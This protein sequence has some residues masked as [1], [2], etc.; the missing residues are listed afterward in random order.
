MKV[1]EAKKVNKMILRII[2]LERENLGTKKFNDGEMIKKI[3]KI[4]EEET[5]KCL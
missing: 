4:I 1:I 3:Q 5:K 2:E